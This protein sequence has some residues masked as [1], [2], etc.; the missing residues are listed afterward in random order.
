VLFRSAGNLT[1][2]FAVEEVVAEKS[3]RIWGTESLANGTG[4]WLGTWAGTWDAG[5]TTHR[6]TGTVAG[7]GDDAG[8]E[9][10]FTTIGEWPRFIQ[11]GTIAGRH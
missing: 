2:V 9:Y 4:A 3:A 1:M 5:W 7:S 6:W 10:R 11:V 8:L